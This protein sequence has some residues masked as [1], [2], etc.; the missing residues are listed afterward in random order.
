MNRLHLS[1]NEDNRSLDDVYWSMWTWLENSEIAFLPWAY[2]INISCGNLHQY[3]YFK[4]HA[5]LS[6]CE[7]WCML[8]NNEKISSPPLLSYA[9]CIMSKVCLNHLCN[10]AQRQLRFNFLFTNTFHLL[11]YDMKKEDFEPT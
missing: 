1:K 5:Y 6:F 11:M 8:C 9:V 10:S 7:F 2:F 4:K 3:Y